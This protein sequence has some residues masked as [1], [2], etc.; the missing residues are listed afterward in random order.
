[1]TSKR[2]VFEGRVQGV[3]FRYQTKQLALGFEVVGWVTN[4]KDGSV[5]LQVMGE[6]EEVEDFITEI[7]RESELAPL[8]SDFHSLDI[9]PLEGCREFRIAT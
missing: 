9:E 2:V 1:M 7:T 6:N 3:G 5:E 8:I 4:L